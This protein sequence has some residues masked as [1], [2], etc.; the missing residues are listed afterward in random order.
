MKTTI[1]LLALPSWV[2]YNK[3]VIVCIWMF[4]TIKQCYIKNL[5]Y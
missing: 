4:T 2:V 5:K 1:Y 3:I